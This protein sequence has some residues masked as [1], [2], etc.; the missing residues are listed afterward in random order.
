M[1]INEIY[2]RLE[3]IKHP[4]TNVLCPKTAEN[5]PVVVKSCE[6]IPPAKLEPQ[7][8][9]K[10]ERSPG[11]VKIPLRL[12]EP[13]ARPFSLLCPKC[14]ATDN[15]FFPALEPAGNSGG[16]LLVIC[17]YCKSKLIP[18]K[19]YSGTAR[20]IYEK[21]DPVKEESP[22]QY[23][24][25]PLIKPC[26]VCGGCLFWE[27]LNG[28]VSCIKCI[29]LYNKWAVL[30]Y[31]KIEEGGQALEVEHGHDYEKARQELFQHARSPGLVERAKKQEN[32]A[33]ETP[34]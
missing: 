9:Q 23:P 20:E 21:L 26:P 33:E 3:A 4:E 32:E 30:R 16:D 6:E 13:G 8:E 5:S 34:F 24:A 11:A 31:W 12:H 7:Q 27:N 10:Q 14:G 25:R 18:E 17:G 1:L 28:V 2:Q 15:F 22:G 29:P 19:H